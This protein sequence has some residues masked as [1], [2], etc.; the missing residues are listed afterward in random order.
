MHPYICVSGLIVPDLPYAETSA[1]RDEAIK[2]ELEL[3]TNSNL[4]QPLTISIS[5]D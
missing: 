4:I 3:V 2:N 1:F 5:Y